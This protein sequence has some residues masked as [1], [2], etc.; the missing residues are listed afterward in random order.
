ME[1]YV[2]DII[3]RKNYLGASL[4][5]DVYIRGVVSEQQSTCGAQTLRLTSCGLSMRGRL[6]VQDFLSRGDRSHRHRVHSVAA[7]HE[8]SDGGCLLTKCRS[9]TD[10]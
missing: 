10:G 7:L 6:L 2:F 4:N 3:C 9:A 8:V 1:S 5:P